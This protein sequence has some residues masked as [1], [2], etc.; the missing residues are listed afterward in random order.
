MDCVFPTGG[1]RLQ[2]SPLGLHCFRFLYFSLCLLIVCSLALLGQKQ[3]SQQ[4]STELLN[5]KIMILF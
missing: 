2:I 4:G 1:S 3:S 5:G